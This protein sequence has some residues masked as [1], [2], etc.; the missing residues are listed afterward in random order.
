M[1]YENNNFIKGSQGQKP[2][3]LAEQQLN[4]CRILKSNILAG[5]PD[6]PYLCT[7]Q[8]NDH[9]AQHYKP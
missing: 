7:N 9:M 5:E 3:V 2:D 8:I 4:N 1:K 6:T